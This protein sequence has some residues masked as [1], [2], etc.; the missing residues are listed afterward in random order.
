M[1]VTI[2]AAPIKDIDGLRDAL[3]NAIKL[4]HA[5]IPPYLT[6]FFTPCPAHPLPS[7]MRN[8]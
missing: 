3:Q 1:T 4:E 2:Q 5:T 7:A 8:G 6:A